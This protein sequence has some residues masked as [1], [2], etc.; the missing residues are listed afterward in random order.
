MN[1]MT[2]DA[3]FTPTS[4]TRTPE[5]YLCVK[6]IAARTGVYQYVSTELDL[7]GPARIVN[8]YKP[9][10]E[11]FNPESMATAIDKDVTND[12]PEDLVDS[13]TFRDVSVGHARGYEQDGEN[14]VVDM[15]IK[16]QSAIDDIESGKAELSPGYTAEYVPEAGI[17][18]DG[19]SYEYVQRIIKYNHFAVVDAARAGKVARIF[20]H[21][22]KGIPPMAT[23]KVFLDSK[24]SRS[25]ILDEE[26][27][28]VVEDA[29]SGL[30]KT[31]DE[32]NERADKAEAAKDEA[33]EKAEEAKKATSD[34]AIGERVKLTLDTIASA[35]K[36]V[37]NFDSKG[38]VSPLEIKRAALA[39]LK[40]TRDWAGKSEAYITAAFDSAEEDAKETTDE[41]D[42]D[43]KKSTNDSLR[44]LA[45]DLKNRPKLTNDGSEAYTNFLNGVTK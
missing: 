39:Q 30:M 6:G 43:D 20:D 19:Q 17:A 44:G 8:V 36:I 25:V 12:H 32:A 37:K 24:K 21:K 18:P 29:V 14:A 3:A 31:L 11:L 10:E 7:P 35:S 1:K 45:N 38:L 4:R 22:P 26:T 33:E 5:G 9:A 2:I 23:R 28:T 27:A 42:E 40:P 41:D 16:D 13:T 34:A 15:I